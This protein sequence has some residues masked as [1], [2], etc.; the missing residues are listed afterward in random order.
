MM[1]EEIFHTVASAHNEALRRG[2]LS[3]WTVY[4]HPKDFPHSYVARRF[5]VG[6]GAK[7]AKPTDDFIQGELQI[8]RESFRHCGLT[9]LTRDNADEPQIIESWL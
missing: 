4:D 1:T 9:C 2:V 3:I 5:E 8:I 7:V 6:R